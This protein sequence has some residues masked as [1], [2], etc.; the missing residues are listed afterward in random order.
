[1]SKKDFKLL[2]S[3]L[4]WNLIPA[5]YMLIRMQIIAVSNVDIDVL[6]QL[7]WFD[8]GDEIIVTMCTIPLY[9]ILTKNG[10]NAKRNST[11]YFI[12]ATVY[13]VYMLIVICNMFNLTSFMGSENAVKYLQI[14][15]VSL[16]I[17]FLGTFCIMLFTLYADYIT[18][19]ALTVCRFLLLALSDFVLIRMYGTNGAAYSEIVTGVIIACI[20]ICVAFHKGY[21][22]FCKPDFSFVKE[23]IYIGAFA[24]LQIFLDN[25]IYAVIVCKMVNAVSESGNYWVANN[26]IW[27]WLLVPITCLV[28]IVKRNDFR[29]LDR[30]WRY[31]FGI[32]AIWCI[33]IP[34]WK[35]FISGPMASDSNTIVPILLKLF[36]F[37]L[38]YAFAAVL[39][40]WFVSKGK[41][42][43]LAVISGIVN[44]GYY[45]IMYILF[46]DNVFALTMNFIIMLFGFGMVVHTICSVV[47]YT[48]EQKRQKKG[49]TL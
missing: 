28:E 37:Y 15:S 6:G 16:A 3:L 24:G 12:S 32:I 31:V 18:V 21:L 13:F 42:L 40:A 2:F 4:A 26:F 5:V 48:H 8:L 41:T 14:Q 17:G 33:S 38:F 10:L 43:Y 45:G 39:D 23:W 47:L 34:G 44:I 29:K 20:S 49:A 46:L 22:C 19:V 1:M 9:S 7:E 27:G 30:I 11:A 35:W 25:F 36:P